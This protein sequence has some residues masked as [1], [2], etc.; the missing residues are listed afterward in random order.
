MKAKGKQ[1][2]VPQEA[3]QITAVEWVPAKELKTY[4]DNTYPSVLDVLK[5]GGM[6]EA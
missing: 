5:A 6:L 2:L 1:S 3:E 4:I